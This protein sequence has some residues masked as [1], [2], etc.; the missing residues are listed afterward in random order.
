MKPTLL[1]RIASMLFILFAAGH[2]LG[3]LTFKPPTP[4]AATVYDGMFNVHF[5]SNYSYGNFYLGMGLQV[6]A[7]LLF[8]ALLA[9]H[10]GG[11]ARTS[12]QSIGGLAWSF[13]GLQV[14]VLLLSIL[15][16]PVP[17]AIFSAIL[18]LCLGWAAWLLR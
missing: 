15:Y 13:C 16:F 11:V 6:T 17:P 7:Y 3:F 10:L 5:Q 14:A 9:W 4:E 12:P 2:T 8:S 1:F 18:A